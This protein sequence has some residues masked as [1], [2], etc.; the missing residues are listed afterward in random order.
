MTKGLTKQI[1][2][3]VILAAGW[4]GAA[5]QDSTQARLREQT[6]P[7]TVV[8]D[9]VYASPALRAYQRQYKYASL[10]AAFRKSEQDLYL[11]QEGSGRQT[12]AIRAEAWQRPNAALTLW[13][14]AGYASETIYNVRFNEAGDYHLVYPYVIADSVGGDMKSE[15]YTF[16]GGIAKQAGLYQLGLEAAFRGTQSYRDRDPRPKNISSE[17]DLRLGVSRPLGQAYLLALD[18]SGKLYGQKSELNF[19]SDLGT[20][21][22]YHDAGLGVYN[23]LLSVKYRSSFYKGRGYGVD[24]QLAP[25]GQKGWFAGIGIRQFNNDKQVDKDVPVVGA[26]NEQRVD[27]R[28]GYLYNDGRRSFSAELRGTSLKRKG[29]EAKFRLPDN[30]SFIQKI[31]ED[32]RYMH[33]YSGAS[34][35][36]V[37]GRIGGA[38]DWFAGLEAGYDD[39]LQRYV[40]P[41]RKMAYSQVKGGADITLRKAFGKTLLSA[42]AKVMRFENI[43]AEGSWPDVSPERANF[44]MLNSNFAYLTASGMLYSGGLRADIPVQPRM[45]LYVRADAGYQSGIGQQGGG[46]TAGIQF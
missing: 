3:M 2:M 35:R 12:F 32:V 21:F 19:V 37:Y 16:S 43:D 25:A 45:S 40:Q 20:P 18:L 7:Q 13:G 9:E 46:I 27:A 14:K 10:Y 36:A 44:S 6:S 28:T 4:H 24:L 17:I 38:L 26:I 15:T 5:A 29:T 33:D 23:D 22:Y 8:R 30:G 11:Q 39:N 42:T 31:S 41:D 1:G 34:F